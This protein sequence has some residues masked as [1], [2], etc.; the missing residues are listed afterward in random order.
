MQGN[1]RLLVARILLLACACIQIFV[2]SPQAASKSS[3]FSYPAEALRGLPID[4]NHTVPFSNQTPGSTVNITTL[5][6]EIRQGKK[7][8]EN[9]PTNI[10]VVVW[11][12]LHV[13]VNAYSLNSEARHLEENGITESAF[14]RLATHV[15]DMDPNVVWVGDAG[16]GPGNRFVWC[17]RFLQM[18]QQAKQLRASRRMALQWPIFILDFSD[19]PREF[20]CKRIEREIGIHNVHYARRSIVQNRHWDDK[21]QWIHPG[22]RINATNEVEYQHIPYFVRTDMVEAL[23][24]ALHRRN[25]SLGDPI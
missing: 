13:Q 21:L 6:H 20:R 18:V 15:L 2:L 5:L 19:L 3:L 12:Y 7:R 8:P 24:E 14:L 9:I 25:L 1:N 17:T 23:Q 4:I 22:E 11:P 16:G 10:P